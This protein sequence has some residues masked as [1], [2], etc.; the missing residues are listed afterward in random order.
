MTDVTKF[1]GQTKREEI[2]NSVT[3]GI[4]ALLA[5]AGTIVLLAAAILHS[6]GAGI[7]SAFF[8]GISLVVLYTFSTLYH[9]AAGPRKKVLQKLDHCSIY[10]LILG[11]YAPLCLVLLDGLASR[12]LFI[13]NAVCAVAGMVLNCLDICRFHK[14]SLAMYLITGWSC[15]FVL[16]PIF[17]RTELIGKILLVAGGLLYTVGVFF[18]VNRTH[19]YMHSVWH[20][21]V[22]G[23]SATHY[24]FILFYTILN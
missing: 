23:G 9:A 12:I 8:Y 14:L 4:G 21:F 6:D 24:F 1:N 16:P 7:F 2:A 19:R 5:L 13:M 10:F 18:Y 11:S 3:H 15:V 22:L 20:L 17:A